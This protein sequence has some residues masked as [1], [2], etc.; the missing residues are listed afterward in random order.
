MAAA[1]ITLTVSVIC[2]VRRTFPSSN[3]ILCS[4]QLVRVPRISLHV[5]EGGH[6]LSIQKPK[7]PALKPHP[8]QFVPCHSCYVFLS[9]FGEK[10]RVGKATVVQTVF[11][12]LSWVC[13]EHEL[14]RWNPCITW[15]IT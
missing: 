4:E 12:E 13:S 11:R 15:S 2:E 3:L 7:E 14:L 5:I 6:T 8:S 10:G 9:D 1:V